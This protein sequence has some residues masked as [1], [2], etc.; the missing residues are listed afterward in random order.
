MLK[1]VESGN[2]D[3][4]VVYATDAKASN[5]V[6]V[7]AVATKDLYKTPVVYP[8]AVIKASKNVDEAKAFL[9]FLSGAKAKAVFEK[10]GFDFLLK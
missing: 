7:A 10:Y 1:W 8:V 3:A 2:A 4:G 6:K 9:E 5:K